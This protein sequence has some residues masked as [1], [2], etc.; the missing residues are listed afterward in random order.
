VFVFSTRGSLFPTSWR[1]W[2]RER[3]EKEKKCMKQEN[4]CFILRNFEAHSTAQSSY[5]PKQEK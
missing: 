2:G 5:L 3:E 4:E 1:R